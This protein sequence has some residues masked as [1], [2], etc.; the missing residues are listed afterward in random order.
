MRFYFCIPFKCRFFVGTQQH[1]ARTQELSPWIP[2]DAARLG[3]DLAPEGEDEESDP[4]VDNEQPFVNPLMSAPQSYATDVAGKECVLSF[5]Q[6]T[7]VHHI[8]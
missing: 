2:A 3:I 5:V 6:Y 1:E 8:Q 4:A 7:G